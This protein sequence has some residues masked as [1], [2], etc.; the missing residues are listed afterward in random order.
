LSKA[1]HRR[2][3]GHAERQTPARPPHAQRGP[4]MATGPA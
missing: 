2:R 4:R 1:Y 3:A